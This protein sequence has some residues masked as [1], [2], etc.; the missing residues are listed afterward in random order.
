MLKWYAMSLYK[1]LIVAAA[2]A[3]SR[4]SKEV[5]TELRLRHS[6]SVEERRDPENDSRE[7]KQKEDYSGRSNDFEQ[8]IF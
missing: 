7:A 4:A 1:T 5:I 2:K 3:F 8:V 6:D